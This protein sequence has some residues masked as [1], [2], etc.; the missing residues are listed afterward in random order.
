MSGRTPP[1]DRRGKYWLGWDELA[2]GTRRSPNLTIFW[3]DPAEGRVR[4]ASTGTAD[5][6]SATAIMHRR[7]LADRGEVHA[8]CYACGQSIA[9]ANAYL[10][11]DAIADYRLEWGDHQ[12][13][14]DSIEARL[15]HVIKF[16]IAE[17]D[18]GAECRFGIDTSCG[19][20]CSSVFIDAFR[21]WSKK[22]P[23]EWRNKAGEVTVSKPRSPATTEESVIQLAAVLNH[24]A[25]ADPPRSDRRPVYKPIPRK[26]VSRPRKVRI[27]VPELAR[28]VKYAAD[29]EGQDKRG[30]L[31][32]FLVASICTIARPDAIVDINISPDR[33]Q[34][35]RAAPLL[36][37]N[38]LGRSQTKKFRPVVPVLP[39]LAAWLTAEL[40]EYE[41]LDREAR[42]GRG[43]LVNYRGRG[44]RDVGKA[45][46]TMLDNLKLPQGREWQ[47]YLL[48]HSLATIVRNRGASK[49]D[50]K[51][52]MGHEAGGTTETYAV[53]EYPT[54]TRALQDILTEIESLAPG[55]L[56][57]KGI[58]AGHPAI[59]KKE[60]KM[61]G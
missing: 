60:K 4:S 2:D 28:L 41:K 33:E 24:A 20:A 25:D 31:H 12:S 54:V 19:T 36:D 51:G 43:F 32:A 7:Y 50:L 53:G 52:F 18:K 15:K 38:P 13:S 11:T 1:L 26:Q 34:W 8:F 46:H 29:G 47:P 57:R 59:F 44:I 42:I 45:W 30:A 14:A 49:W 21:T 9:Q 39:T 56:H 3:Y 23:V 55:A 37:L 35:W 16:L 61:T 22:Q 58:G 17:T 48:R 6:K 40:D 5:E 27:D 10:L